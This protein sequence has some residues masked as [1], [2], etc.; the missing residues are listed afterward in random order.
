MCKWVGGWMDRW[1]DSGESGGE[2]VVVA[3]L[4]V[5]CE[6]EILAHPSRIDMGE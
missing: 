6:A 4:S 2:C 5:C 1:M 3:H